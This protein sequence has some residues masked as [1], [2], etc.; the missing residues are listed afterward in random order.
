[1]FAHPTVNIDP[2]SSRVAL[3]KYGPEALGVFTGDLG[4]DPDERI[5]PLGSIPE[6]YAPPT[7]V[8]P[9][10]PYLPALPPTDA[11][12]PD[13][14]ILRWDREWPDGGTY[15]YAAIKTEVGWWLTGK[16]A[17]PM[18]W[19]SLVV[20]HLHFAKRVERAHHWIVIKE[21]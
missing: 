5:K 18:N 21:V 2:H 8:V 16:S 9:A 17:E 15:P 10:I 6:A 11:A 12:M 7:P 14:T 13:G 20:H 1:M 3:H 19:H 4:A